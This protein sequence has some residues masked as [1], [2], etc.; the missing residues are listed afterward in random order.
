LKADHSSLGD[1]QYR[2]H[3][4]RKIQEGERAAGKQDFHGFVFQGRAS[5]SV[6]CNALEWI[7]SYG[8]GTIVEPDGKVTINNANAIKALNTARSWIGAISPVGVTTYGEEEAL[9]NSRWNLAPASASFEIP[10]HSLR[11]WRQ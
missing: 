7:Y 3:I 10:Q 8:G 6:T 2:F 11:A 9:G 1:D 5:E 4:A